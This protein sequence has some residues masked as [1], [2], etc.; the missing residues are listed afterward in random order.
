MN[1]PPLCAPLVRLPLARRAPRPTPVLA[2]VL[3][4]AGVTPSPGSAQETIAPDR[5]GIGSASTVISPGILQVETGLSLSRS[6]D[7]DAWS[8]GQLFVRYG[9][10]ERVEAE[11]LLNSF[12]VLRGPEG[13]PAL[14]AE[15]LEDLAFGAKLRV[16]RGE[17]ATFSM[18]GLVSA[19]TGSSSFSA[20]EWFGV[21]NGLLDVALA[22]A[23]GLSVD[24]GVRPG[25]GDL[26]PVGSANVTPGLSLGGG[27]GVY[28]GWA[29]SFTS[30]G[31]V[32]WLEGGTTLL[33]TPDVQLDLN[34]AWS[35]DGDVWFF[36][37]GV[38]FRLGA[39]G[40]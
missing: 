22:D 14:D 21:V 19:R 26:P 1:L 13:M 34:G 10:G 24:A 8:L 36:G 4:L 37:A 6:G 28:G 2:L 33:A 32:N 16:A 12:V 23:V 9:L 7:V 40:G 29:G 25:V 38:A 17:R 27:V 18:Q 35:V 31:D 15:G 20:G 39:A 3:A 5:P 11:L 30:D